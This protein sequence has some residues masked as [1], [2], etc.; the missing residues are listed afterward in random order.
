MFIAPQR[1]S[2]LEGLPGIGGEL[3]AGLGGNRNHKEA[4]CWDGCCSRQGPLCQH[5]GFKFVSVGYRKPVEEDELDSWTSR[6]APWSIRQ[7]LIFLMLYWMNLQ[8]AAV[9]SKIKKVTVW[10]LAVLIGLCVVGWGADRYDEK[11][12]FGH[13]E[14]NVSFFFQFD[15]SQAGREDQWECHQHSSDK[16]GCLMSRRLLCEQS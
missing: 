8:N 11:I 7:G 13:V 9:K 2:Q 3:I 14:L 15:V 5:Q 12:C 4:V 6:Y 16:R 10:F 1:D